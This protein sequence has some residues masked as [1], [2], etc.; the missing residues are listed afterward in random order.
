MNADTQIETRLLA[1]GASPF[2]VN[3]AMQY[4]RQLL[5]GNKFF[6]T[7]VKDIR[8]T[9]GKHGTVKSVSAK[10]TRIYPDDAECPTLEARIKYT[11]DAKRK[12]AHKG[13]LNA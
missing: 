11:F 12:M 7:D 10:V 2:W 3:S 1:K 5:T 4:V 6:T 9:V 8:V 13:W